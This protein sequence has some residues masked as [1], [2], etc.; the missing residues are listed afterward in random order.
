M[1]LAKP[2]LASSSKRARNSTTAV[3]S[4]PLRAA[5]IRASTICEPSPERYS[6]CLIA[7]T[8]G[9]SA[10]CRTS[11]ST[12]LKESNGWCSNTS[13]AAIVSNMAS[14][15][16][17]ERGWKE[18]NFRSGRSASSYTLMTRLRFTGPSMW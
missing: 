1:R 12:G 4:L 17:R 2:R 13:P 10:A 15:P 8:D 11:S 3:T 14:E 5:W 7:S 18:G 16:G 6:V 9:S